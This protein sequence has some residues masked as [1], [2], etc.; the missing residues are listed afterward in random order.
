MRVLTVYHAGRDASHRSRFRA[1]VE[2]GIELHLVVPA[3]W[4]EEGSEL[5]LTAE[6]YPVHQLPVVRPGD[7]NR[8]RY[9]NDSDVRQLIKSVRP[10]IID[11]Q[12][13]P[14]STATA[15]WLR[16]AEAIPV[17]MYTAQ[18]VDKRFPPPFSYRE[19]AALKRADGVYACT[20]QAAAVV[21]GK[22][23]QGVLDVLPLGIGDAFRTGEQSIK[24]PPLRLLMTG[25]LVPEKGLL[26]AMKVL[27]AL[28]RSIPAT[29]TIVG[30][31]PDHAPAEA[32]AV[33]LGVSGSVDFQG[34]TDEKTLAETYR[35]HHFLLI[36]S[37]ATNTWA[38]QFGRVIVEAQAS[39]CVV[40]GYASGAIP[41][42]AGQAGLLVDEGDWPG[43]A[44][45]VYEVALAET[46]FQDL[47]RIGLAQA[48]GARWSVVAGRQQELY[49]AITH[50]PSAG[51]S[52]YL[53]ASKRDAAA[54]DYGHPARLANGIPRPLA[55]PLLR[56]NKL[57]SLAI[58]RMADIATSG[59]K[60]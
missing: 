28:N 20:R 23:F 46:R 39:G 37:R 18:N 53:D 44:K 34:W 58:G 14:V 41:E 7:V 19:T 47:R 22:G 3:T 9:V 29:L 54:E 60:R 42:V 5:A 49:R 4:P 27:E 24:S 56:N 12:E 6:P 13:E 35:N 17:A 2:R 40:A 43:L 21:R 8:H 10:D 11:L 26:D 30:A 15:Q 25:R 1:L 50:R 31:G 55:V 36:P 48:E 38:E 57:L 16:H 51:L 32:L 59:R 45:I 52:A 33:A